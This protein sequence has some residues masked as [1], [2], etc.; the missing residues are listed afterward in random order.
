MQALVNVVL[1]VFLVI[2][3]GYL[4]AWRGIVSEAGFDG[5]MRYTSHFAVPCL[6]FTAISTLDLGAEF[7]PRLLG[8][9][10]SVITFTFFAGM[11]GAR[12]LFGR[13]W[14]DCVAIG[15]CCLFMNSVLLGLPIAERAYGAENLGP[16]FAIIAVH[17][18]FCYGLGVTAMEIVRGSGQGVLATTTN[19]FKAMF[20]NALVIAIM[21]GFAANIS[22]FTLPVVVDEA[23]A[24]IVRSA[25]PVALIGIGGVLYRY[26]P[27]GDMM[28]VAFIC[29]MTLLIQ[30]AMTWAS[31]SFF[32]LEGQAF[33]GAVI[34]AAMAPGIN[35]YIFADLYG[36][37]R[38]VAATAVL[39]TTALSI[40]TV[41][42]WLT[43]LG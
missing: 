41:W 37:A 26:R 35:A 43:L 22:G 30:P 38:R 8:A 5:L 10:Y 29:A 23:L 27:E 34:T 36:V 6:L 24:L 20:R 42:G 21:L 40:V 4:V 18:P 9:Y 39:A 12:A 1:P 16:N 7:S 32:G 28:T 15:F 13:P 31:S 14:P 33:K 19:V 2:G 25:L 17:A 11:Y 3:A